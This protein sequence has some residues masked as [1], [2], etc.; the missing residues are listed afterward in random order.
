M[1]C[2]AIFKQSHSFILRVPDPQI[3]GRF[4]ARRRKLSPQ[5]SISNK[6]CKVKCSHLLTLS[7]HGMVY[8][9]NANFM[10]ITIIHGSMNL[11][12]EAVFKSWHDVPSVPTAADVADLVCTV[13]QCV[14]RLMCVTTTAALAEA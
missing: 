12:P 14:H 5:L 9:C 7:N 10:Q 8:I 2:Q 11:P 6:R 4:M 1:H 13:E 3:I